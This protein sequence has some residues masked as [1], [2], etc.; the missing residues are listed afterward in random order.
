MGYHISTVST[1]KEKKFQKEK[2]SSA[3]RVRFFDEALD[4]YG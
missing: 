2:E 1:M 3:I 4:K